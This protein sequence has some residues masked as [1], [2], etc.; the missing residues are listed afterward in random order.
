MSDLS[1]LIELIYD[2]DST[3]R[4]MVATAFGSIDNRESVPPLVMLL[5]DSDR[6]VRIAAARSL[7][8]LGETAKPAFE[9]LLTLLEDDD[10]ELCA[11]VL[12][13]LAELRDPRAFAPIVVR[14]FDVDDEIRR[15]AAAAIGCLGNPDA[16]KPLLTCLGDE[17]SRVRA[18]AAWSLGQLRL[19]EARAALEDVLRTDSDE[20]VRA[21]ALTAL[22][23]MDSSWG[24]ELAFG[25]IGD[26]AYR[27]KIAALIVLGERTEYLSLDQQEQM[28]IL[29]HEVID[30]NL[31]GDVCST[32]VWSLGHLPYDATTAKILIELLQDSYFWTV[33]YAI[34]SLGLMRAREAQPALERMVREDAEAIDEKN[35]TTEYS[36][37]SVL[38]FAHMR[39]DDMSSGLPKTS[40]QPYA[41]LAQQALILIESPQASTADEKTL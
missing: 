10:A 15:N 39:G 13:A 14:L 1:D 12:A 33:A 31:D 7:G 11:T 9:P 18:N 26:A 4:G 37:Q 6:T 27:V 36:D 41:E 25:L 19:I 16:L 34:E 32:A 21:M 29:C 23:F 20:D 24:I 5:S 38:E 3:T 35:G 8:E 28:R 17:Y 22:A 2:P 40:S 30:K